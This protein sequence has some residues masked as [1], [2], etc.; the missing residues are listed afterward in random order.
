MLT[1]Y[2]NRF[3]AGLILQQIKGSFRVL[4]NSMRLLY[5]L[6]MMRNMLKETTI[7]RNESILTTGSG[8]SAFVRFGTA[9]EFMFPSFST[10]LSAKPRSNSSMTWSGP[11]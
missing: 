11:R 10:S 3:E 7:N 2:S 8:K 9:F 1:A 5:Q 4:P 6:G